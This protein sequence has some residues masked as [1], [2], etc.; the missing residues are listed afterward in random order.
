MFEKPHAG[1]SSWTV[2]GHEIGRVSY[3]DDIPYEFMNAC[4]NYIY[5]PGAFNLS[6][7]AE[8]WDVGLVQID[9]YFCGYDTRSSKEPPYVNNLTAVS[10]M[11]L[12]EDEAV[13]FVKGMLREAIE[14]FERDFDLWALW[15][16]DSYEDEK[17]VE[18]ARE[19]LRI[20]I[21]RSKEALEW[22]GF[23]RPELGNIL[24]GNYAGGHHVIRIEA[25][26][27]F[28]DAFGEVF[29]S[30][31]MLDDTA[32]SNGQTDRGGYEN[33]TFLINPY[34]WGDDDSIMDEPNF[35]YKPEGICIRWYKYP[36]RDAYS[37]IPLSGEKMTEIFRECRKSME[38]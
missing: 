35:I 33:D 21:D 15:N 27:A 37:N 9:C 10:D 12:E 14:D 29:D 13:D 17:E 28:S 26:G 36:F 32:Y 24:F 4:R 23:T 25:E 7:D 11:L 8:G 6:F 34:Y 2:N 31:G 30:Y 16:P 22:D 18:E 3:L 38:K 5:S 20:M 1:W 19:N